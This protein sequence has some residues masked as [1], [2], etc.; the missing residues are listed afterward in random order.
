[1]SASVALSRG[2]SCGPGK[3]SGFCNTYFI[4]SNVSV[5]NDFLVVLI[6]SCV[7]DLRS[8]TPWTLIPLRP[9]LGV[10]QIA[11]SNISETSQ[12]SQT[13]AFTAN[14]PNRGSYQRPQ[15]SNN[16]S[17]PSTN[18]RPNDNRNRRTAG[19]SN[20]ICENCGFNVTHPNGTEAFITKIENMPLTDYLTLFDVL[21]VLEYYVSLMS[22]HKAARDSKLILAFDEL[23]CYILNQDLRARKILGTG[24]QF[25]G[26]YY[27]DG[28]QDLNNLNFLMII[29]KYPMVRREVTPTLI[30]SNG[31]ASKDERSVNHEDNQNVISKGN[32]SLFSSQND[33]NISKPQNLRRSSRPY[34]FPRNYNDFVVESKVKYGLEKNN[35]WDLVD[36][37]KGRK[38]IGSKRFWKIKYK[39]D[40]EIERY[41]ARLVAKGFNQRERIDFDETFSPVVK[42]VTIRCLINLVVQNGWTLYQ[43]NVNNAF[44]YGDLNETVYMS[45]PPD[46]FP[47]D[48]TRVCRLNKSLYRLK[49]APR[50]WNVKL[51]YALIEC[52]FMQSKSDYSL[53]TKKFGDVFIA[54]LI[55]VDDIIITGNNL[56]EINKPDIAYT[57][58][59]LSRL[60]HC[61]LKS[62]LKTALKV[63]R[64]ETYV[65][66]KDLD[67][68]HVI[69]NGDFQP[70]VQNPKTK[71]DEVTPFE[72]QT[73]DLKKRLA[74][75][76]EAKMVIYNALPRKE[77]ERIFMCNMAKEI[78]KT[79][80]ITH[81][82]NSQ[83]K[84]N[85]ID[86]LVQ[87]YEQFVISED[88]SIDSAFAR[89]NTIITSLK[90]LD[91]GYSSK[92]Y[93][94]KFLRALHPKWRAKVT[95]IEE[96]KDLTSLSLDE[97]IGNLKVYEM[98]IKKDSEIV[99]AKVERKSL[100]LKAKKESSDE[101]CSTSGS[102]DEE[103]AMAVRD[104]K[105]FFKRRGRFVRQPRNDKKAFQRSRDDKNGKGDRKC[106]RCGNPN[107][108]IG[109]CPKPPK[110]KNQRAFVGG[111]WSDSGEEDDKKVKDETCLVAHAS[112][113]V[114]SKSSYFS[115]ENS[116]I[117]DIALDNEYDNTVGTKVYAA[118][119]Q[120]LEELLL[121][122]ALRNFDLEVM[123]FESAHSNTIAKLP[124]LKLENGN[125][126]VFVPQI[127]Q[128]NGTSVTKMS[129]PVTAEEKTNKKNDVKARSL[130]LM[131]LP[132][133]HQLTFSQYND[134]KTMFAAI[135]TRFG[136]NEATKKT[137]KTLLKQQYENFSAS[138]TESL[139][140]IF[141]R[142]QKIV[143]RLAILGV[144][145]TQEDLNL[146]FLRSLPPEWNTHVVVW[147]NKAEIE[148]MSIDDLYNNFKI[149]EQ[150]VKKSVGASSGAQNLAFMTAPSTSSTNDV[151]TAKPAY[152][153]STVSPN[154]NTASPQDLEQIHE[155][156]LEVMDLKWQLS[157]LSMRAKRYF[158]RT[159]KKIFINANDTAGYDKSK[160][161]CFNCHK[162]G[163]FARECRAPRN[164]EGQFRNQDNTRK[165]GNN[166][167]KSSK[168]MLAID[169][170]GFDWSDMAEEQVQ[171]NMAL[172][173]FSDSEITDK[174]KK[175]L[176]YNVVPPPHPLIYNRPKKLDLSYYGL[177]EFK[178]PEFKSYGSEDSKQE[179]NIVCDKKSDNSKEN[180]DDSLVKEQ[181]SKDTSSFVE[182]S[183]NVV[184]ETIFLDKKIEFVKPKNHEKPVK[185][186]VRL[187][188]NTIKGKGWPKAVNTA[189][190]HSAVVNAVRVN[191]ANAGKLLMDDK[192][193]VLHVQRGQDTKVPQSGG[194]PKKVGDEAVH[195]EL[196]D[197]MER[198]ATTASSLEAEQDSGQF[199]PVDGKSDE[200]SLLGY[201]LFSNACR[202]YKLEPGG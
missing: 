1:M 110:D 161:E 116:S 155:D 120:L 16:F 119:L 121:A 35:T 191:Q 163:H 105:K 38:A 197:R 91:E 24:R 148:T 115:D 104:F 28:N 56:H 22:V 184:K 34:V 156:D 136:G 66:S 165:H 193:L 201:S 92:N 49:Q 18:V 59:C 61:P 166:K 153:V 93:V 139:D 63:I 80:L 190:P 14:V 195:K 99:K 135:E 98:I 50:Q 175:G 70:I 65:K 20:L 81:Q 133:E 71:L 44:L 147:M 168:A 15:V 200:V 42:I 12:R 138:S 146:K 198:A 5:L 181:V 43:M 8:N 96:S 109:E 113:E 132:N 152:E 23:K 2:K 134:A 33:Q 25:G 86:L 3:A 101:E 40:G 75:N 29:L 74:K 47:K 187:I 62:H 58:S 143:S 199:R 186:S 51:T 114:C 9:N 26:L 37:P 90:A 185:K 117:D 11:S 77:Y 164:K 108:L 83:V 123:E 19:G 32:G 158:Q 162:M 82:G 151:N 122:F 107:H 88:E 100:A 127:A 87:Q 94:R 188:A 85:K 7:I 31:A 17:R 171:T 194:P 131:A 140:S 196:G 102:E 178:E 137:Q 57:V 150:S 64:F 78:W 192:G 176:G 128:E 68:W 27:F 157:L 4:K 95:A 130:L 167:D 159:C 41:K 6:L 160:V 129:V 126:W 183:L 170:I 118:G 103:Y 145:I 72:K 45:L 79:L 97:L 111:S 106:F 189:R 169:G 172:M 54:L 21:V 112:S 174:S 73:D 141:N 76:N 39:S 60:M 69:T 144:V 125:S 177:D 179:S 154:V 124:I 89:F 202:A 53:F 149:V 48:E 84:D 30:G 10:L 36:L 180:S 182:S 13:S 173:A 52:D 142:L 67:L 46:Y 55:Y